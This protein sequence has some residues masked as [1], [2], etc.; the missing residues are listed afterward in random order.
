MLLCSFKVHA[1][2]SNI[3]LEHVPVWSVT[4]FRVSSRSS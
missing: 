1:E 3:A 2:E 4:C